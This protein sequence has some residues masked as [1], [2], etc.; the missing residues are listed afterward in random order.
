MIK[1]SY[2]NDLRFLLALLIFI[3][4][5]VLIYRQISNKIEPFQNSSE[6]K[7]DSVYQNQVKLL[8]DKYDPESNKRRPVIMICLL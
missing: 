4:I 6:Y 2:L 7:N 8:S 3:L 5:S 1:L